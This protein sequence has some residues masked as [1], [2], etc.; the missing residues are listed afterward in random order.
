MASNSNL[1]NEHEWTREARDILEGIKLFPKDSRIIMII[2]HSYRLNAKNINDTPKM[3]LTP[4]GHE[5]AFQFGTLLPKNRPI[6]IFHSISPRCIETAEEIFKGFK[7]NSGEGEMKGPLR[8]L[9]QIGGDFEYFKKK[10]FHASP[11]QFINRWAAG[12][13]PP[14]L[15]TP[16]SVFSQRAAY[17][18][19]K[20]SEDPPSNAIDLHVTHD[21]IVMGLRFGWFGLTPPEEAVSFLGGIVMSI[22]DDTITLL[23]GNKLISTEIPYWWANMCV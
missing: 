3:R 23:D 2:R 16:L 12:H 1:W 13:Y 10:I 4:L 15:M 20:L 9:Y 8:P 6:R 19:W 18:I 21:F 5:V 11:P 17:S 14:G 22:Q 7:E